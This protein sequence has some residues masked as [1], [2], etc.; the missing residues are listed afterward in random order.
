MRSSLA[1]CKWS[2]DVGCWARALAGASAPAGVLTIVVCICLRC[3]S[4]PFGHLKFRAGW[5]AH[6]ARRAPCARVAS[7]DGVPPFGFTGGGAF[8]ALASLARGRARLV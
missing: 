1:V 6:R 8:G 5:C 4:I 7:R 2:L 3:A